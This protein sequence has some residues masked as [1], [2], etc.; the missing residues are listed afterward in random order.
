MNTLPFRTGVLFFIQHAK[1]ISCDHD[2]VILKL[3][4]SFSTPCQYQKAF[5][6]PTVLCAFSHAWT[7]ILV[8]H[9]SVVSSQPL[10]CKHSWCC[11]YWSQYTSSS[12]SYGSHTNHWAG[13]QSLLLLVW[14]F[15]NTEDK[16]SSNTSPSYYFT[17]QWFCYNCISLLACRSDSN[18]TWYTSDMMQHPTALSEKAFKAFNQ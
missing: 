14:A 12:L 13:W 18:S 16:K 6:R 15:H 9:F 11:L 8:P 17:Y 1:H 5:C 2:T 4:Q 3:S 10:C 7:G